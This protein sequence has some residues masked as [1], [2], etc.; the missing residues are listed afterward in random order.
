VPI[1]FVT[2]VN[3][4][5]GKFNIFS[6]SEL[7]MKVLIYGGI[8]KITSNRQGLAKPSLARIFDKN[9]FGENDI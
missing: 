7:P 3:I 5:F 1:A 8:G 9:K 2:S 4:E 6:I